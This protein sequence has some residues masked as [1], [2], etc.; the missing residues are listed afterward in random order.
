MKDLPYA[1]EIR[2]VVVQNATAELDIS[3][4]KWCLINF[5]ILVSWFFLSLMYSSNILATETPT[6][7]LSSLYHER[8]V[9]SLQ[10]L[11]LSSSDDPSNSSIKQKIKQAEVLYLKGD[12]IAALNLLSE[13]IQFSFGFIQIRPDQV[14]Q[15]TRFLTLKEGVPYFVGAYKRHRKTEDVQENIGYGEKIVEQLTDSAERY[16]KQGRYG[17]AMVML[18]SAQEVITSAIK[19]L[20]NNKVM[21][22][23]DRPE[24]FSLMLGQSEDDI[25]QKQYID[26]VEAIKYF[27][28]AHQRQHQRVEQKVAIYDAKLVDWLMK[29][30]AELA[31]NTKYDAAV[32]VIEQARLIITQALRDTLDGQDL[33][34]KFD[35]STPVLEF[36]YENRRFIGYDELI[37]VAIIQMRPDDDTLKL[38]SY[39]VKKGQYMQEQA[40]VR[41]AES[42]YPD[43]IAMVVEATRNIQMALR[44]VG[45][46]I[47][48]AR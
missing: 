35:I 9:F 36:S 42:G 19:S 21:G 12:V 46:P 1:E 14:H 15:K 22:V 3:P 10:L 18:Q 20:L 45:V 25:A 37:P 32:L 23:V 31:S 24:A 7:H 43:A 5:F 2:S 13:N 47:Y 11:D 44:I 38:M 17:E 28:M 6:N 34:V 26:D 16:A 48:D 8:H 27:R 41:A 40:L 30:A 33:V 29:E 39:Y 4:V